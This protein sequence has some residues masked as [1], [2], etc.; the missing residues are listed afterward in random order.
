MLSTTPVNHYLSSGNHHHRYYYYYYCCCCY[1][2][3]FFYY[4]YIARRNLIEA[5]VSV[6]FWDLESKVHSVPYH[7]MMST[8]N[9]I[10]LVTRK[11]TPWL[12]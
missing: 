10:V 5:D 11:S 12:C 3:F 4:Y 2:Y 6:R 7:G 9:S 1:Y 8:S